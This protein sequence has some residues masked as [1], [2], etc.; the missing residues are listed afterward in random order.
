MQQE[1]V[2]V[3]EWL[4]DFARYVRDIDYE[5]GM[6]MF[7]EDIYCFGSVANSTSG[8]DDLVNSQ[9]QKI[10]PNITDFQYQLEAMQCVFSDDK[11]MACV[12]TPWISTGYN[13]DGSTFSRP[14]RM[15]LLLK[16]DAAGQ[17]K[18][19]HTHYSVLPG[20][21]IDTFKSLSPRK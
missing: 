1:L 10:W 19:Q 4:D 20:L 17:W 15:T 12:I 13:K 3:R 11:K 9:W 7:N 16:K 18:A 5:A 14:G 2:E 21:T 6:A 8:L